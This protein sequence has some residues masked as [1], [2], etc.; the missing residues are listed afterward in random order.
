MA[1]AGPGSPT[2]RHALLALV[3]LAVAGVVAAD[4][5]R[6]AASAPV[7]ALRHAEGPRPADAAGAEA[8][9]GE[10]SVAPFCGFAPCGMPLDCGAE[11]R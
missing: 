11:A 3:L 4:Y 2:G 1:T 6:S 9:G 8:D 5:R 7:Q 10:G